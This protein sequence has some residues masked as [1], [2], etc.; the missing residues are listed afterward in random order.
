MKCPKTNPY[1]F[2][3]SVWDT[4]IIVI[5]FAIAVAVIMTFF[6]VLKNYLNKDKRSIKLSLCDL[7]NF[8]KFKRD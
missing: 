3:I 6:S 7:W 5:P 4:Y 1:D 8:V 2:S